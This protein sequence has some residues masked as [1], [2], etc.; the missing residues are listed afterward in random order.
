LQK[1][2]IIKS[3]NLALKNTISIRYKK[4]YSRLYH[5]YL[6]QKL[7]SLFSPSI[8]NK[9]LLDCG[10]G[11]GFT[12][13]IFKD[14]HI[15]GI[16]FLKPAIIAARPYLSRLINASVY[17]LPFQSNSFDGIIVRSLLHHLATPDRAINEL[18]RVLKPEG[19]IVLME[20]NANFISTPLRNLIYKTSP[21]FSDFHK[22]F[23]FET[24]KNI[25]IKKFS[26]EKVKFCGYI[27]YPILG[28]PDILP[29]FSIFPFKKVTFRLLIKLDEY[30]ESHPYFKNK[31]FAVLIK[32]IP[33]P[34]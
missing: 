6:L 22:N 7:L 24:L 29:L 15:T 16:D 31:A 5:A 8:I 25:L 2:N 17:S 26:I 11:A 1:G 28:F 20:T 10:C 27:A 32:L 14:L 4:K 18:H 9:K 33:F 34:D 23:N 30:F 19:E 21:A 12:A 13:Q 3:E